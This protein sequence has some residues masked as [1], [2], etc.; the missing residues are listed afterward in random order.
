MGKGPQ[1]TS[2]QKHDALQEAIANNGDLS[3]E[4]KNR[5]TMWKCIVMWN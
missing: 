3:G 4:K 2:T 5:C 1:R